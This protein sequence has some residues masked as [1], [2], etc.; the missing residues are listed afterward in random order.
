[1]I[2][3][4]F[5]L[6]ALASFAVAAPTGAQPT[7]DVVLAPGAVAVDTCSCY[8]SCK[9]DGDCC[10]GYDDFQTALT[11]FM[12]NNN[13]IDG[14][15]IAQVKDTVTKYEVTSSTEISGN[16]MLVAKRCNYKQNIATPGPGPVKIQPVPE[17]Q[18]VGCVDDGFQVVAYSGDKHFKFFEDVVSTADSLTAGFGANT[19]DVATQADQLFYAQLTGTAAK[20][21]YKA[22]IAG[23]DVCGFSA[24]LPQTP[25]G[26]ASFDPTPNRSWAIVD[27][28]ASFDLTPKSSVGTSDISPVQLDQD[29][30]TWAANAQYKVA[31]WTLCHLRS[32]N[33]NN[34]W[35]EPSVD[36][37]TAL[38]QH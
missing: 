4:I 14:M 7:C 20:N 25:S 18:L 30:D 16:R 5:L 6:S 23:V 9:A 34:N 29:Y 24:A 11:T 19:A 38:I 22:M 15:S 2:S 13:I 26:K 36:T 31:P 27:G 10:P 35:A 1:M 37:V 8:Q 32:V 33:A 17:M 3:A 21:A 12:A 28:S